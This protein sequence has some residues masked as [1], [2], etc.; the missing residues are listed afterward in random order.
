[1][2]HK[3]IDDLYVWPL[4]ASP[5]LQ[6]NNLGEKKSRG[7]YIVEVVSDRASEVGNASED[8]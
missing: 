7:M 1:M 6:K 2:R 5:T 3:Y 4:C 8:T